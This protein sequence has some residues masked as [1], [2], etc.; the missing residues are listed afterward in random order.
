M[1]RAFYSVNNEEYGDKKKRKP[2][3]GIENNWFQWN[4]NSNWENFKD[5][6]KDTMQDVIRGT[7][8][9]GN[10]YRCYYTLP[11]S[12]HAKLEFPL[13]SLMDY[14]QLRN[15]LYARQLRS[16]CVV[17]FNVEETNDPPL[18]QPSQMPQLLPPSQPPSTR[19]SLNEDG[20]EDETRALAAA[21]A[22]INKKHPPCER[23]KCVKG[24][25]RGAQCWV[26]A[27][28]DHHPLTHRLRMSWA[29][30][31]SQDQ[32]TAS[33]PPVK[34]LAAERSEVIEVKTPS[35]P[36]P[37]T[38]QSQISQASSV[39]ESSVKQTPNAAS[40]HCLQATLDNGIPQGPR[41]TAQSFMEQCDPSR[42]D[43][44]ERLAMV[45][46]FSMPQLDNLLRLDRL[47]KRLK[48]ED[49][50]DD[51]MDW[52]RRWR[53]L[54]GQDDQTTEE[55]SLQTE[56]LRQRLSRRY[57]PSPR[58]ILRESIDSNRFYGASGP[59]QTPNPFFSSENR[60]NR[61]ADSDTEEEE[62]L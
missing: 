23:P 28:G 55:A 57:T 4:S 37:Q 9:E 19:T 8:C 3:D 33:S 38:P 50:A 32:A 35:L 12:A 61:H 45:N 39:D 25:L 53:K 46:V 48:N 40:P 11:G 51:C 21:L 26:S 56:A 13:N 7:P 30:L 44:V 17:V 36:P 43:L 14:H 16:T 54:A 58:R 1:L 47:T 22:S 10:P 20:L 15:M 24:R 34:L 27:K 49:D 42:P 18:S 60:L 59:S 29:T 62:L 41:M 6:F 52:I 2:V 31:I 5:T